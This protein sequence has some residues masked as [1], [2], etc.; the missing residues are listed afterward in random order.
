MAEELSE[1]RKR[2]QWFIN[3][4]VIPT[5]PVLGG[6]DEDAAAARGRAS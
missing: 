5:E 2:M 3:E 6:D 4:V 1:I